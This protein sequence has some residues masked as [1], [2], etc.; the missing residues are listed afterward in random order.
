[1]QERRE[2]RERRER[3]RGERRECFHTSCLCVCGDSIFSRFILLSLFSFSL[4]I[5]IHPSSLSLSLLY[6]YIYIYIYI[7]PGR[8]LGV[9]KERGDR[10]GKEMY[11]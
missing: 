8:H 4:F 1:V 5:R 2:R 7:Y 11:L 9:S 3:E 10:G 6:I